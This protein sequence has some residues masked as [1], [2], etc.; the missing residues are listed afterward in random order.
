M[1][2][3]HS[4]LNPKRTPE[5]DEAGRVHNGL[6]LQRLDL[7]PGP[8]VRLREAR[9]APRVLLPGRVDQR[10]VEARAQRLR[11]QPQLLQV[12]LQAARLARRSR[13]RVMSTP[14]LRQAPSD[15]VA[16]A[17]GRTALSE[18]A[19]AAVERGRAPPDA[20][21]APPTADAPAARTP[22]S[23]SSCGLCR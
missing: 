11:A 5:K 20:A 22:G 15:P 13:F 14:S 4:S 2:N 19:G 21:C 7:R 10:H 18:R 6:Q 23:L 17:A 16:G 1:Q 8:R 9:R 3:L 12:G